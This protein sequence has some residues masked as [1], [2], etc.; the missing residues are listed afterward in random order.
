MQEFIIEKQSGM[1]WKLSK[2]Q[3]ITVIDI[4]GQ[5]VADFFAVLPEDHKDFLCPG[6]TILI[7]GGLQLKPG[8]VLY[9]SSFT[10]LFKIVYDDVGRHDLL[11][12]CCSAQMYKLMLKNDAYHPNCRD[13]ING[14]LRQFGVPEFISIQ[15]FNI[16]M[17]MPTTPDSLDVSRPLSKAGDKITLLAE[18]DVL[19]AIAACSAD[20]GECNAGVCKPLKVVIE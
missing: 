3:T 8:A 12:P 4:E 17:N 5:Q 19:V 15:P 9:S 13:N 14:A 20:F 16:F 1:G 2:G 11:C 6:N 7:N 18:T 10:P